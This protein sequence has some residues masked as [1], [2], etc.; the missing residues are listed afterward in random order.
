MN[1]ELL[2]KLS[3]YSKNDELFRKEE[4]TLNTKKT[5]I[6]KLKNKINEIE[7]ENKTTKEKIL[8]IRKE[9][10]RIKITGNI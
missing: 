9:I 2:K 7:K 8:F 1:K 5:E 3:E 6:I 4:I 10:D